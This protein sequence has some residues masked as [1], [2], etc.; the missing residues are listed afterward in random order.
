M[1]TL[2]TQESGRCSEVVIIQRLVL[3]NKKT[4]N[5]EKLGDRAGCGCC[6]EVVVSTGFT[7]F[8]KKKLNL[9]VCGC[10]SE[11]IKF[12][13]LFSTICLNGKH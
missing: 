2:E 6:S 1:A 9:I 3:K 7:E 4:E 11:V 8:V 12:D 5:I 13:H 10:C